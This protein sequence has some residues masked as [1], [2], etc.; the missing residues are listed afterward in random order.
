MIMPPF[1]MKQDQ[2]QPSLTNSFAI[3]PIVSLMAYGVFYCVGWRALSFILA[4]EMFPDTLRGSINGFMLAFL[5]CQISILIGGF[6]PFENAV[7]PYTVWWMFAG[8]AA[9]ISV[10]FVTVFVLRRKVE[11]WTKAKI[12]GRRKWWL[13]MMMMRSLLCKAGE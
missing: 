1:T 8:F 12:I 9:L 4:G 3:K 13:M 6:T 10:P 2:F 11:H 7:R 5:W